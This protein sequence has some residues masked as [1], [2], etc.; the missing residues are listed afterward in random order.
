M[1]SSQTQLLTAARNQCAIL[2]SLK[3]AST[4]DLLRQFER[5]I[6]ANS[7][8]DELKQIVDGL[9]AMK[10]P[11]IRRE[12]LAELI[13]FRQGNL[14]LKKQDF[15]SL[16]CLQMEHEAL[17]RGLVALDQL[18]TLTNW[19]LRLRLA[20]QVYRPAPLLFL[21]DNNYDS[22]YSSGS[23]DEDDSSS[24]TEYS[25]E[26]LSEEESSDSDDEKACYVTKVDQK[27]GV[28]TTFR[29]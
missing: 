2:A 1:A 15:N 23:I 27:A 26:Y 22:G 16:T 14:N 7:T 4:S 3:A 5:V 6:T 13:Y 11:Y 24:Y 12:R 19:E 18:P 25:S 29:Y 28:K 10:D 20:A 9:L 8:G 17:T 21:F